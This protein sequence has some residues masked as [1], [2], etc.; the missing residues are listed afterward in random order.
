[1]AELSKWNLNSYRHSNTW[2]ARIHLSHF[3]FIYFPSRWA[4]SSISVT[5]FPTSAMFLYVYSRQVSVQHAAEC[6]TS[7]DSVNGEAVKAN[8]ENFLII[9][10]SSRNSYTHLTTLLF[11]AECSMWNTTLGFFELWNIKI[12]AT[13]HQFYSFCVPVPFLMTADMESRNM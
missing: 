1:M 2:N 4:V 6:G 3:W 11:S 8:E 5:I 12:I 7:S 9:S 10:V 13:G